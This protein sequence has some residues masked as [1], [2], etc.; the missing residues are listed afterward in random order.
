MHVTHEITKDRGK[1]VPGRDDPVYAAHDGPDCRGLP[2]PAVPFPGAQVNDGY[3]Y[4]PA[5]MGYSGTAE[6]RDVV[7]P[8]VAAVT[9]LRVDEVPDVAVL[10]WGP[11]LRGAVVNIA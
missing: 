3:G 6:E 9:G 10:L 4:R 5:S 11:L 8:V 1:Y 2:S 7:K